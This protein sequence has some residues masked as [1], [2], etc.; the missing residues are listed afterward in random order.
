MSLMNEAS[1]SLE[2]FVWTVVGAFLLVLLCDAKRFNRESP[3]WHVSFRFVSAYAR[4]KILRS[5][6]RP[7]AS[8]G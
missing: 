8:L 5:V 4:L 2:S 7:C 1:L 6:G 3:S